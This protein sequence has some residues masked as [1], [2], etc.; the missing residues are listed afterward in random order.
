MKALQKFH[1]ASYLILLALTVVLAVGA[2]AAALTG[3]IDVLTG[4]LAT[5]VFVIFAVIQ[6]VCLSLYQ[7]ALTV[8][9]IGFYLL[10]VGL[11]I[12]LAGFT[13]YAVAGESITV[14]VPISETGSYYSYV[15]NEDGEEIDL[16]F[17]FKLDGFTVEKYESG[18]DK[19]YR[20]DVSFADPTTLAVEEDYLEVNRTLRN[21]GWKIYLMSYSDGTANMA[22][23]GLSQYVYEIYTAE[24]ATAGSSIVEQVYGDVAGKWYSYYLYDEINAHFSSVTAEEIGTL[25]GSIWAYTFESEG[26]VT[27][28]LT[29]KDGAFT[30]TLTATGSDI[31]AHMT[32]QYPDSRISYYYYT[33]DMGRATAIDEDYL[34]G[35]CTSPVYA[36]IR[37]GS[38]GNVSVYVMKEE[39]QPDS[40]LTSSEGGSQLL[41]QLVARH[42]EAAETPQYR[43]Y[44]PSISDYTAATEEEILSTAGVLNAYAVYMGDT[45]VIF[46]H[47]LSNILLL[48]QNPG[49]WA[50]IVG[51]ILVMVGSVMMCLIKGRR[52]DEPV[53]VPAPAPTVRNNAKSKGGKKR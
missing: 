33:I 22:A 48:K 6:V 28:Y 13:A 21:N 12:L 40:V 52:K 36:G 29:L 17:A 10:H 43:I 31:A 19:Y 23:T 4:G 37:A 34:T 26:A 35:Q 8:Y 20:T 14:Q 7:P 11:L 1:F 42:G 44:S 53:D 38:S 3:N 27:V 49:E 39:M 51:M 32:E 18:N 5:G 24:G 16:G 47:P 50:T 30:E 2:A 9:R 15:Q 45:P 41:A 46:V 25:S